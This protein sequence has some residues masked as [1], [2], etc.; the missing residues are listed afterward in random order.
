MAVDFPN[1]PT[2]GQTYTVGNRTWQ[3]D[4]TSW[5]L[6]TTSIDPVPKTVIDAKGDLIVGNAADNVGRLAVGANTYVLTADSVE[7]LGVKWAPLPGTAQWT[8]DQN[9]LSLSTF[10]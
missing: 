1:S 8:S 9:I 5:N 10:A 6:Q 2:V 3:W 7:S 4:G